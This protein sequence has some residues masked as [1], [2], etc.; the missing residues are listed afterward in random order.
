LMTEGIPSTLGNPPRHPDI[1][2]QLCTRL[3]HNPLDRDIR[4]RVPLPRRPSP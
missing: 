4:A 1:Y 3:G 2:N